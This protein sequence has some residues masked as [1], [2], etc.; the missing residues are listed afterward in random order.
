MDRQKLDQWLTREDL[1]DD[2]AL[3]EEVEISVEEL[4]EQHKADHAAALDALFDAAAALANK[5]APLIAEMDAATE[6]ERQEF[7]R[8]K[9]EVE[10]ITKLVGESGA[11]TESG[12]RVV[13]TPGGVTVTWDKNKLDAY[14]EANPVVA[15][16]IRGARSEKARADKI[17][18]YYPKT[19]DGKEF[20]P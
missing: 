12:M 16:V 17:A 13:Y 2:Q 3:R 1:D 19:F 8:C 15:R 5:R 11:G 4:L 7:D 6:Q 9:A 18:L 20:L 10:K 14:M